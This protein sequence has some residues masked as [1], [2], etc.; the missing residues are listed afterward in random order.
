MN[1][2]VSNVVGAIILVGIAVSTFVVL[3]PYAMEQVDRIF[4]NPRALVDI[5]GTQDCCNVY[6]KHMGGNPIQYYDVIANETTVYSGENWIIGETISFGMTDSV[7]VFVVDNLHRTVFMGHFTPYETEPPIPSEP[8][9]FDLL[10]CEMGLPN[11][12]LWYPISL[13]KIECIETD[14]GDGSWT[15][16][17]DVTGVADLFIMENTTATGTINHVGIYAILRGTTASP[18]SWFK[19]RYV[20]ND[21]HY[22]AVP[23]QHPSGVYKTYGMDI[24]NNPFTEQPWTWQE[25]NDLKVYP[26][27]QAS[28]TDYLRITKIWVHIEGEGWM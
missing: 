15:Y 27:G 4:A 19:I 24:A 20:T 9:S 28:P 26:W 13:T 18:L 7:N 10:P 6:L 8:F 22:D 1:D 5:W 17:L 23:L 14:D 2:A 12:W 11:D 3:S 21:T 16:T 25:V